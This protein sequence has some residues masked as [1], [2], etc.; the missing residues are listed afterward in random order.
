MTVK[1]LIDI[2][3]DGR[4]LDDE[5]AQECVFAVVGPLRTGI[6]DEP[7]TFEGDCAGVLG[8]HT[9]YGPGA[10][11]FQRFMDENPNLLALD[12]PVEVLQRWLTTEND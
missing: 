9:L 10:S 6:R 8:F 5:L 1:E 11:E 7:S 3:L 2:V 12:I 4:P